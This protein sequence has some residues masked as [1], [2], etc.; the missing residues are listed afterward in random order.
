MNI[1]DF[2]VYTRT[3]IRDAL[4]QIENNATGIILICDKNNK[5]QGIATDGDIRRQLLIDDDLNQIIDNCTNKNFVYVKEGSSH[6]DIY[7]VMDS[8]L[9]AI[10]VVNNKLV[11]NSVIS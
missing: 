3:S 8:Q 7:K 10:P 4:K 9:K 5:V 6:E 11:I 2:F 1:K